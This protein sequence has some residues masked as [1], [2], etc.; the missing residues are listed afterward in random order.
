MATPAEIRRRYRLEAGDIFEIAIETE[1][2]EIVLK[3]RRVYSI[4]K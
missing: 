4:G 2:N 1:N 3:Y